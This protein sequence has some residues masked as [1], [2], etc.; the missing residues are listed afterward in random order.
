MNANKAVVLGGRT[1]LLG[2]SLVRALEAAGWAVV[3]LG[4][5]DVDIFDSQ[6]LAGV[7]D[8]EECS[9]LFNTVAYTQVDKA[10]D[11]PQEAYRLN[12]QLPQ[13]LGRLARP[14]G[15]RLVHYSTDF[16]FDGRADTPYAPD[17]PTNPLSVYGKS[18]LAGERA[19]LNLDVPSLLIIRTSWLFGPGKN[20]FVQKILEL[21]RSRDTL[22][23]VH[24][25]VGSPS[26]TLDLARNSLA[27]MQAGGSGVHHL[28]NAGQA[29]WCELASEAVNAAGLQCRVTPISTDQYPTKA[30][31]PAYSVLDISRFTGITGLKPRPWVQC[32]R[33][34]VFDDLHYPTELHA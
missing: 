17:A 3:P 25:Q 13:L 19:L 15:I 24:D 11:E 32:L 33:E 14:R 26:Y 6:A 29:S 28:A 30:K 21:A 5:A 23:V 1:G 31:R 27:L 9:A 12:E 34:Y 20:N 2:R 7:L 8:R 22:G 16:V 10:E 4:R 18:K